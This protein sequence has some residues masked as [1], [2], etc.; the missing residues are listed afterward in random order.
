[1]LKSVYWFQRYEQLKDAKNN[2]KQKTFSAVFA[3]NLKINISNF[4]WFCLIS[5][6]IVRLMIGVKYFEALFVRFLGVAETMLTSY[7]AGGE[8]YTLNMQN[9][10]FNLDEQFI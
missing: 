2:R 3:L 4:D 5:S 7:F 1:M 6:H 10:Q 9:F 8:V